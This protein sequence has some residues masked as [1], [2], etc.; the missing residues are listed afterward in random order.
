MFRKY[1]ADISEADFSRKINKNIVTIVQLFG[2][3]I[4]K[5]EEDA[6]IQLVSPSFA[7]SKDKVLYHQNCDKYDKKEFSNIND[8]NKETFEVGYPDAIKDSKNNLKFINVINSETRLNEH[9]EKYKMPS[10]VEERVVKRDKI[11]RTYTLYI[12]PIKEKNKVLWWFQLK[13]G[14]K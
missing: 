3:F 12:L 13:A 6:S 1:Y 5:E 14:K 4:T 10:I 7:I 8:E 11:E 2:I 9:F